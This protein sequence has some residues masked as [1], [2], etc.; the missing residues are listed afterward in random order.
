[1]E[2]ANEATNSEDAHSVEGGKKD[3]SVR[4]HELL[5]DSGL[6][7]VCYFFFRS[8]VALTLISVWPLTFA[9]ISIEI[10]N[11]CYFSCRVSLMYV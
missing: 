2:E 1:M 6:A 5:V 10:Y 4:R 7:E 11:K 8:L 3:P 9:L